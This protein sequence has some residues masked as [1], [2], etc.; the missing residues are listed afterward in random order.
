MPPVSGVEQRG[1]AALLGG[2]R[3]RDG[4]EYPGQQPL[5]RPAGAQ[6][7]LQRARGHPVRQHLAPADDLILP[8][9]GGRERGAVMLG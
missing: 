5:P 2:R 9:Q 6:P 3:A 7:L 4:Q 8:R 1:H